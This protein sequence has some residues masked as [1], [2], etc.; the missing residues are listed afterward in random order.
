MRWRLFLA[1]LARAWK[2]AKPLLQVVVKPH[3]G[4]MG[5][6]VFVNINTKREFNDC[7][8][9]VASKHKTVLLEQFIRGEEYRFAYVGNKIG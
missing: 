7:F 9:K 5:K 6:M 3:I 1:D 4:I 2:W 8:N